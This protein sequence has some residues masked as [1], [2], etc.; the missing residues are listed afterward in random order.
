MA[1]AP[2]N[3]YQAWRDE[4]LQ[5]WREVNDRVGEVGGWRT[6]LR[7]AQGEMGNDQPGHHGHH[8]HHGQ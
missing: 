7:E 8:G 6:Y 4:P 2:F 3:H 5:D 1:A